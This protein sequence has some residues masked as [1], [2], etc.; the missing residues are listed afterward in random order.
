[1]RPKL[2]TVRNFLLFFLAAG[3]FGG[4]AYWGSLGFP[5]PGERVP[6]TVGKLVFVSDRKGGHDDLYLMDGRDGGNVQPLTDDA[7]ADGEPRF[8]ADGQQIVFTGERGGI[9]QVCLMKAAPGQRV[10]ALTRTSSTKEHPGFGPAGKIFFLD[11]GKIA[12][13]SSDATDAEAI[14]PKAADRRDNPL[15]AKLFSQ[16]GI[17]RAVASPDGT[18]IAAVVK[19]EDS[20]VLIVHFRQEN[21]TAILGVAERIFCQ[22][23]GTGTLT[24]CFAGGSPL[25]KPI[26]IPGELSGADLDTANNMPESMLIPPLSDGMREQTYL[27]QFDDELKV[28]NAVPFPVK[29]EDLVI[30]P[31][32]AQV[33]V[34]ATLNGVSR[35]VI[36]TMAQE[37]TGAVTVPIKATAHDITWSPDC[38]EVAYVVGDDIFAVAADGSEAQPRNLTNG[39]GRNRSPMWSPVAPELIEKKP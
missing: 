27:M 8:S 38:G 22:F 33:A 23:L 21:A 24:A 20:Q 4:L 1:M 19:R 39:K 5:L 35:L 6:S 28:S 3:I 17:V 11:G 12:M 15:I 34:T 9:R 26:M 18:R 7:E 29:P 31:N 2:F 37:Q 36:M 14:F 16:G 25:G 13:I 30:A 32:E 10:V